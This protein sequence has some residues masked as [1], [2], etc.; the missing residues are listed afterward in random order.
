[1]ASNDTIHDTVVIYVEK[2][3]HTID[4]STLVE[5]VLHRYDKISSDIKGHDTTPAVVSILALIAII[6]SII[7]RRRKNK[8]Q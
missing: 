8:N 6:V 5:E 3:V 2:N 7:N 1:M 4:D